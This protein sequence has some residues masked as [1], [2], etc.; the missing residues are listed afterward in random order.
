LSLTFEASIFVGLEPVSVASLSNNEIWVVNHLSDS[1][2]IVKHGAHGWHVAKTLLVGD[3]PRDIIFAGTEKPQAFITTA[4]RGQNSPVSPELTTEGVGRANVWVFDVSDTGDV[5]GGEPVTILT[6]FGDTPRALA[7]SLDK[8]KVFVAVFHSGNQTVPLSEHLTRPVEDYLINNFGWDVRL[9]PLENV[10]GVPAPHTGRIVKLNQ[11]GKF[12]DVNGVDVWDGYIPFELPDFDVFELDTSELIPRHSK[13][14][15]GVGTIL[16]NMAV[17]PV[18]EKLYVT[19]GEANNL[20][21]FEGEGIHGGSTVKSRLHEYRIT[22]IDT[23]SGRVVNWHQYG[24]NPFALN[25]ATKL[26]ANGAT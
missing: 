16:F 13:S 6:L 2:S 19:N 12:A 4:R 10:E 9:R 3:E 23:K 15:S 11:E 1:V 17:N 8:S 26:A 20:T 18:N 25:G 5:L 7:S 14:Y 21:R 22:S 24:A